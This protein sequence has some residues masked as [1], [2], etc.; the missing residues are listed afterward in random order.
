MNA[1]LEILK[2]RGFFSQCTDIDGLS[3][4]MDKGPV[5]FYVG[6]DPTGPSLHIGHMVPFF[7][8]RHLRSA[9]HIGIALIGGG[10]ARIGDPSGKTEMRKMI[11]YDQLAENEKHIEAQLNKFV[12][13]DGKTAFS[14]NNK[15]WLADLNYIDFLRDI[16]SC[17]SVNKML[18]FEA[19][20]QRL[21]RGLSFIEFNYQLLQSYDFLMLH[22]RHNC[23]LQIGG[24]DQWGNITAGVDLIRRKLGGTVELNKEHEVFGLTF[25]LVT[26]SDGNKMGKTEKG[27]VFLDSKMTSVFDFFQYWRNVS[28]EDVRKFMLLFTFLPVAEID[29][30]CSGNIN[31]AKE[32]LAYEV[33]NI[34]HGKEEAD[35]AASGARAAFS[36]AGDKEH[37]PSAEISKA[38]L[39]KGMGVIDLFFAAN[40]GSTKSD[41]RRLVQQ[42]GAAVNGKTVDDIKAVISIADRDENGDLILRSGKK[43]FVRIVLK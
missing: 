34:I 32:R 23:T 27:A 11:S 29:A 33:T 21:E 30:L 40:M 25:P 19:Y 4:A 39:E 9:G 22:Q 41:V 15:N 36:G 3:A 14:D 7:A 24:D 10:T 43:K 1:A 8:L 35:N 38:E 2:E 5:T 18:S 37:M 12:G 17:F 6:C 13:F 42:G 26:R 31:K 28:D 16:G 20:K